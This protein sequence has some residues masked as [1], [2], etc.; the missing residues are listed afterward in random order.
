MPSCIVM[1]KKPTPTPSTRSEKPVL[2]PLLKR[3]PRQPRDPP[4]KTME[5]LQADRIHKITPETVEKLRAVFEEGVAFPRLTV[6]P[7]EFHR[8]HSMDNPLPVE[9]SNKTKKIIL[10]AP[11]NWVHQ[12]LEGVMSSWFREVAGDLS[13]TQ[14]EFS[15]C[16][17]CGE[18]SRLHE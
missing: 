6:E 7:E 16:S 18:S 12:M 11:G 4:D 3:R 13:S 14:E 15:A 2:S 17:Q 8:W 5:A 1:H 9:Y 10:I